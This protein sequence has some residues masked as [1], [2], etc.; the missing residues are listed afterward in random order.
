[1]RYLVVDDE[2]DTL[3]L[4]RANVRAWGHECITAADADAAV[5]LCARD[6]PDVLVLDV[7]M[8]GT[9]GPDLLRRMRAGGCSPPVVVLV[10][11]IAP[12]EL[13]AIANQ[14]GVD[15]LSKPFTAED[16]RAKMA[17][18]TEAATP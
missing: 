16:F 15:W 8:P 17:S 6:Q 4:V 11:A 18:A 3:L 7:A 14:L 10:S 5:A 12:E 2:P 9:G 1:M 13:E